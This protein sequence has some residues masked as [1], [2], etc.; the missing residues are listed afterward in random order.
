MQLLYIRSYYL[1]SYC[2]K[3]LMI[4]YLHN[5]ND[6]ID[7]QTALSLS[8]GAIAGIAIGSIV[9]ISLL[10]IVAIAVIICFRKKSTN[11]HNTQTMSAGP[12]LNTNQCDNQHYQPSAPA[13]T[14]NDKATDPPPTYD[15]EYP[16]QY[17]GQGFEMKQPQYPAQYSMYP[18]YPPPPHPA[19]TDYPQPYGYPC[20]GEPNK[21]YP[22]LQQHKF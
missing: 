18:Q 7:T 6:L 5:F 16:Y 14:A 9:T 8:T 1:V 3:R 11:S 21:Y 22:S 17:H 19:A 2:E 20:V 15:Q 13:P 4:I 12:A 10:C